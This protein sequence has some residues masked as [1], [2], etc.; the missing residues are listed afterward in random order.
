V[1]TDGC[2]RQHPALLA[3]PTA[4][5]RGIQHDGGGDVQI[6]RGTNAGITRIHR[7][8]GRDEIHIARTHA[9]DGGEH[10]DAATRG[11]AGEVGGHISGTRWIN[12]D[13]RGRCGL[14][15]LGGG[16]SGDVTD[17]STRW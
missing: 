7:T 1:A 9:R 15:R 11:E 14:H 10:A 16:T 6:P 12:D 8:D 5:F 4:M 3:P 2:G 17:R 13:A